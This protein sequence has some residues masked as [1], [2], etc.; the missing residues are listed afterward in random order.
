MIGKISSY[1]SFGTVDGPGIRFVLFMGGCPLRCKYCHNPESWF[2]DRCKD[3]SVD[4]IVKLVEKNKSYYMS[5]GGVTI[6]GGEPLVQ[7]DFLIELC[8]SLKEKG[9]NVAIDTSG[10]LFDWLN[11]LK[12]NELIKSVDLFLL[13]IKH[14]S[15]IKHKE[16]TGVSN[17]SVLKFA[18]YLDRNGKKVWIRYVLVPN[19]TDNECDMFRLRDFIDSLG[20]VEKVEVLPYHNMGIEKYEKL[21]LNY[22]LIDTYLPTEESICKAMEILCKNIKK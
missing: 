5:N 10:F 8:C 3:Y 19:L 20:N 7:L 2:L 16:I 17:E 18:H 22:S 14:I 12:F 11:V 6:S 21:G 9:Y 1:E 13:D 15:P 4:E